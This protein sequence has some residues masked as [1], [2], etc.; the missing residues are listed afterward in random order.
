[1]D[2]NIYVRPSPYPSD[3]GEKVGAPKQFLSL[4]QLKALGHPEKPLAA[5]R[6]HCVGCCGG[7]LA[8]VRKC[9]VIDCPLWCY[10]D[11]KD[12]FHALSNHSQN[13]N[14]APAVGKQTGTSENH[15]SKEVSNDT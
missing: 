11:G 7:S 3:R 4:Q 2:E 15:T 9:T 8:E 5:I 10:R 13:K 14:E 6:A 1:M 12:P